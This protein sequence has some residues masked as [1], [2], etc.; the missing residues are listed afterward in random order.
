[1]FEREERRLRLQNRFTAVMW[2]LVVAIGTMYALVAGWAA[3]KPVKVYFSIGI[4]MLTLLLG[5]AIQII[6]GVV[7][8]ARLEV[9][10]DV[11]GLELRLIEI[12]RLLRGGKQ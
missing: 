2:V 7:G 8:R 6:A 9:A 12:E 1:M 11:K 3:E 10:K 5:G 4:M